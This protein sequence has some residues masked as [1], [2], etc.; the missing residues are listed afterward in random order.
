MNLDHTHNLIVTIVRRGWADRIVDASRA[1]GAEGGTIVYGR[2]TG[3]HE[4]KT[5]FGL[6]VDPEKELILTA[7]PRE[8]TGRVL[9]AIV[10]A[11]QLDR[12]ATGVAFVLELSKVAGIVH[13]E[14]KLRDTD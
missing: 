8:I 6:H 10:E 11:G 12:P 3:I 9:A 5:L 13:L 2:G 4:G 1:A 7:V 14:R